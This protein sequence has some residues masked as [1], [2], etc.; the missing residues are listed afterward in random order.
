MEMQGSRAL[1]SHPT[2]GL[3]GA[4]RSRGAQAMHPRLRQ[5]RA[6]RREPV[7][8]RR[9]RSRSGPCR[10]SSPAR[11][12]WPTSSRRTAT[13]S[14]S[15]GRAAWPVSARAASSVR[16]RRGQGTGCELDY[17][18][19]AQVGG[20]IAQ[21]GQ[22]LIDGAARSM[23]EDFFKRFDA[24]MQRRYPG[25]CRRRAAAQ[26]A[27]RPRHAAPWPVKPKPRHGCGSRAPC[28]WWLTLVD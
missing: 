28:C 27:P 7:C 1:G 18:V 3:G 10:P 8:G 2:A 5:V 21:M 12:R 24:E 9:W 11:S 14:A 23:A 16:S 20:K 17:T 19:Q 22:R 15:T 26:P 4:Q 6:D 13:P 25:L